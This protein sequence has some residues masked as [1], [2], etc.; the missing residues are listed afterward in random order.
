MADIVKELRKMCVGDYNVIII[1]QAA[2]EI[3]RLR[4]EVVSLTDELEKLERDK[5]EHGGAWGSYFGK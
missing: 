1:H 4:N 5:F 2:D 3:E